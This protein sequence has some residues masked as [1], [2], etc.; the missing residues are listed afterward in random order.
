MTDRELDEKLTAAFDDI[1]ADIAV[2]ARIRKGLTG[3]IMSTKNK[4]INVNNAKEDKGTETAGK[5][6]VRRGGRITAAAI[7]GVLA[8]G[9]GMF[10]L[11]NSFDRVEPSADPSAVGAAADS[12]T[13]DAETSPAEFGGEFDPNGNHLYDKFGINADIWKLKNG[14]FLVKQTF[15]EG[16]EYYDFDGLEHHYFIYDPNTNS[17]AGNEIVSSSPNIKVFSNCIGIWSCKYGDYDEFGTPKT[18][19]LTV[20]LY[21]FDMNFIRE[22]D[23]IHFENMMFNDVMISSENKVYAAA[24]K[25]NYTDSGNNQMFYIFREDSSILYNSDEAEEITCC[26]IAKCGGYIY[27][28]TLSH[29]DNDTSYTIYTVPVEDGYIE[30]HHS[31]SGKR[32]IPMYYDVGKY[33][34][35]VSFADTGKTIIRKADIS[36]EEELVFTQP[37]NG[38]PLDDTYAKSSLDNCYVSD[39][40][41]YLFFSKRFHNDSA[42]LIVYDTEKDFI[43]SAVIMDVDISFNHS[44]CNVIYDEETEYVYIGGFYDA[45]KV[46][47]SRSECLWDF[48]LKDRNNYTT[49]TIID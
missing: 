1:Q 10:L 42:Y 32:A 2:K 28:G 33:L 36:G 12:M 27:Y 49:E 48:D 38:V 43:F 44:G 30:T 19:D 24:V 4:N 40:G 5:A 8:V 18:T 39:D 45:N 34:Y 35:T 17:I 9:G 26:D 41:K 37:E 15:G 29:T 22:T 23:N 21:D 6:Q 16:A 25:Y 20:K 11:K 3:D 14:N 7:A 31:D 47:A 13:T 46:P